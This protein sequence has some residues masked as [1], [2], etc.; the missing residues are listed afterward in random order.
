MNTEKRTNTLDISYFKPTQDSNLKNPFNAPDS[1]ART[2]SVHPLLSDEPSRIEHSRSV[3]SSQTNRNISDVYPVVVSSGK[4]KTNPSSAKV[5]TFSNN[6]RNDYV[7]QNKM[8]YFSLQSPRFKGCLMGSLFVL[9][10]VGIPLVVVII[11]WLRGKAR[12]S[13]ISGEKENFSFTG[14]QASATNSTACTG[15]LCWNASAITVFGTG[16]SGSAADH[17]NN[18]YYL[19]IH[20]SYSFYVADYSNNRVQKVAVFSANGTT[21]AGQ[22]NTAGGSTA[23]YLNN[24]TYLIIDSG[25]NLY[26]SDSQNH[27]VQYFMNGTMTGVTI[28]G[29]GSSGASLNQ[30]NNPYGIAL[31]SSTGKLYISDTNNHR[32]MCYLSGA[33]N[34]TIVAGGNGAGTLNNQLYYPMGLSLHVSSNSLF[35]ANSNAHNIVRWVVNAS[36]WTLM[37]GTPNG[38]SGSIST[39]LNFPTDFAFDSS[40]NL[41]VADTNNDR[42][43]LFL[44]GKLNGTTIAGLTSQSGSTAVLLNVP[45][46]ITLDSALNLYVVD[47]GNSRIQKFQRA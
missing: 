11:M 17:L 33:S 43:Q 41:Y 2:T 32:I 22:A 38:Q 24:P 12:Y 47:S 5:D 1:N 30:L 44:S 42:V 21:V 27:R 29:T 10:L 15:G 40:G 18:P 46:S 28:A 23:L 45:R 13:I 34:G 31:D 39:M 26:V 25:G 8:K 36:T 3:W 20:S 9:V 7:S 6:T 4:V 14:A 16:A 37:A 19:A 35:I